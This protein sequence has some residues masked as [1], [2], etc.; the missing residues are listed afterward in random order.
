ML[1]SLLF[2]FAY[3]LAAAVATAVAPVEAVCYCGYRRSGMLLML[4]CASD[5][6]NLP[7]SVFRPIQ[8]HRVGNIV[9]IGESASLVS[10]REETGL[11]GMAI[12]PYGLSQLQVGGRVVKLQLNLPLQAKLLDSLAF[13][14]L[15]DLKTLHAWRAPIALE[16]CSLAGLNQ[17]ETLVLSCAST[18]DR[19]LTFGPSF[20]SIRLTGC[21]GRPL[22]FVCSQ[23]T[24][25]PEISVLRILP[26]PP[27]PGGIVTFES[28]WNSSQSNNSVFLGRCRPGVCSDD[29][30]CRHNYPL[31]LARSY[32]PRQPMPPPKDGRRFMVVFLPILSVILI[33]SIAACTFM[34]L[35]ISRA[36]RKQTWRH[37]GHH[38][39]R[40]E[41]SAPPDPIWSPAV[42]LHDLAAKN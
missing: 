16:A 9:R 2:L 38:Q 11:L 34:S 3:W 7:E 20:T 30:L 10:I 33:I 14:G 39:V 42:P 41:A 37:A 23:C 18:F 1:I 12:E 31:K 17:L 24:Q 15:P 4:R 8:C 26:G 40:M 22:Q 21:L 36:I 32:P 19:F 6:T 29:H 28:W 35:R 13:A 27:S 5:R 25:R